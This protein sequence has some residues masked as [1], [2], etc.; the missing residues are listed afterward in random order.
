MKSTE[1][2][3]KQL[4]LLRLE[5][6]YDRKSF[7]ENFKAAIKHSYN[8]SNCWFPIQVGNGFYNALNQ[9]VIEVEYA[10]PYA[11]SQD[12]EFE[13]GKSVSFFYQE[14]DKNGSVKVLPDTCFIQRVQNRT[15]QLS[16]S[17]P[18]F[19]I[20]LNRLAEKN[21][22]GMQLGIDETTY[23]VM[24]SS[25]LKVMDWDSEKWMHLREALIG[26]LPPTVRE[27]PKL[28]FPLL[29]RSQ[30]DAVQ[31]IVEAREVAIVHG[32]P[33]TGKTTTLVEAII[34]TTRREPQ[35]LVCAPSN[36]AIDWLC[37]L[38]LH[39]GINVL[40]VGNPLR[41]NKPLLGCTYEHHY[42]EHPDYPELWS[43]RKLIRDINSTQSY[44]KQKHNQ[45]QRL[46][47][48]ADELEMKIHEE[49][50]QNAEVIA[51]TLIGSANRVLDYRHFGT[52]FIDEATQ[53]LEAACWTAILKADR[54]I[55]AGDHQQLPPT[56]K[57]PAAARNGLETTLMQK[58][59]HQ[60]PQVVTLLDTQYR[61]NRQ[62]MTF[63]SN[64][65][66]EGKL[67]AAPEVAN[68][69]LAPWDCPL[70]W[71]DTSN[72]HFS[73]KTNASQSRLN[74]EEAKLLIEILKDYVRQMFL[75][76]SLMEQTTYGIISPYKAQIGILRHL[77]SKSHTLA[78]IRNRIAVNTVDGFQGQERDIILIS[79]VRDN[80]EG[81]IGFLKDLRRMNV[82]ITRAKLK[83]I[84]I[85]NCATLSQTPFYQELLQYFYENGLVKSAFQ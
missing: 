59:V 35:V 1:S 2:I 32:P 4:Q 54:V 39:R 29:N 57:C 65:F 17:D 9:F 70:V 64:W 19:P 14:S 61:M 10:G 77:V 62:I 23:Q 30:H 7:E 25:L 15:M 37:E 53:A 58:I 84:V 81:A 82:A 33:G 3:Q 79:M 74:R 5:R 41:I 45:L 52:V 68:R 56:I 50:L 75:D 28:S 47:H 20:L 78:P 21:T 60:Q 73:E 27:L 40:R 26:D 72:C 38:L 76:R 69:T 42:A 16:V 48:R 49:I 55:F 8:N 46:H 22:L 11:L 24:E 6:D 34:E 36:A 31:Q 51:C 66:Y 44:S 13:P 67:K 18:S 83:L 85:G 80:D 71:V 63:S 43:I 12:S